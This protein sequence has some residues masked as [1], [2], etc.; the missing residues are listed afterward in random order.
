MTKD[1]NDFFMPGDKS[2]IKTL[3]RNKGGTDY[4]RIFELT[5][6]NGMSVD[7]EFVFSDR[8]KLIN[9]NYKRLK[10]RIDEILFFWKDWL[11]TVSCGEH[12]II[13]DSFNSRV[14]STKHTFT[15]GSLTN[16]LIIN[17]EVSQEL[18]KVN[19]MFEMS[20]TLGKSIYNHIGSFPI[21]LVEHKKQEVIEQIYTHYSTMCEFE[22]NSKSKFEQ[23]FKQP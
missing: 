15:I 13:V 14:V 19:V 9:E 21:A 17:C 8:N 11:E 1:D 18:E 22:K 6:K 7:S 2:L 12:R 16:K 5:T 3:V 4:R 23:I 10:P 20:E